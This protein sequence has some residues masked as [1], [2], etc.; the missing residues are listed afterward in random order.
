MKAQSFATIRKKLIEDVGGRCELCGSR[1]NI[2]VHHIIPRCLATEIIGFNINDEDNLIVV[3]GSCHS[4]LTPRRMLSKYGIAKMPCNV[5]TQAS[6]SLMRKFY[7]SIEEKDF[8]MS[9]EDWFDLVEL[10]FADYLT[11]EQQNERKER[12]R[13]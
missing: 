13:L 9:S 12:L 3:C 6:K 11:E 5:G 10:I 4:K 1:R 7:K 8:Y 2:E